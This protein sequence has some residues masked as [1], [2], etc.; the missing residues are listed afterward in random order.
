MKKKNKETKYIGVVLSRTYN[1]EVSELDG[2]N[3]QEKI[4][5]AEEK[6]FLDF[7][8][9]LLYSRLNIDRYNFSVKIKK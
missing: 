4:S 5:D 8:E 2:S 3:L 9:E 6:A 1:Y 7:K